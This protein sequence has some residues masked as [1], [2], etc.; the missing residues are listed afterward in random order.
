LGDPRKIRRKHDRPSHPWQKDRIEEEK[1]LREEYGLKTKKEIW[2][3]ETVLRKFKDQVKSFASRLDAQSKLEEKQL[4][5]KIISLG[6]M[7]Q[8][9]PLDVVLGLTH[10]D[11]FERR[12]QTLLVRK[13]LAKTMK[14]AR[15]FITHSHVIVDKKKISSPGYI[16]SIKEE[17]LIEF[18][19][20][21]DLSREDHPERI[22]KEVSKEKIEKKKVEKKEEAPLVFSEEEI[23]A[24]EEKGAIEKKAADEAAAKERESAKKEAHH[25]KKKEH[26]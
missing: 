23:K 22:I 19:P 12:L 24:L 10:K 1:K 11:I 7:K 9:D 21:S 20:T 14:Q 25:E 17:S 18:I 13:G 15:Q 26:K 16:V 4:V 3:M 2:K 8:N 5:D 6:L